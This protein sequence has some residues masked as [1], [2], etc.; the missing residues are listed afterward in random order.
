MGLFYTLLLLLLLVLLARWIKSKEAEWIGSYG[1]YKVRK[2]IKKIEATSSGK[3]KAYH[4]L[5][6]P[7]QDGSTS[8]IDH[9]ILSDQG[10]FVIETKNYSG[11]IFGD[12]TS[13]YWTQVI[14]KRKEKFLNPIL[15]NKGHIKALR[16]WLG[17]EFAHIPM[18]SVVVFLPRAKFKSN[19]HFAHAYVVYPKQ[20]K[21]VLEQHQ[22]KV[23]DRETKQRLAQ[24]L[25]TVLAKD[26]TQ[27]KEMKKWHMQAIRTKQKQ[28]E[29]HIQQNRCP[30]C[31]GVLI[32]RKGKYG[33]FK[34]CNN[35]PKCKFT[36]SIG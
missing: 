31:G 20:L 16:D 2:A 3:Y 23:I 24:K 12:E 6:I 28:T 10:L 27:E 17:E 15:Q 35:Y 21:K 8:Q 26:K 4:N 9:I 7:K 13:K 29:Q 19:A 5:Y 22:T 11:W 34:G 1:E 30:K 25:E 33:T 18:H 32:V 36:K 14:Y